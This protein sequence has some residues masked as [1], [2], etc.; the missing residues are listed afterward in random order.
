MLSLFCKLTAKCIGL[1]GKK[2]KKNRDKCPWHHC[3]A[4]ERLVEDGR[5]VGTKHASFK[6]IT[7]GVPDSWE[8]FQSSQMTL[9]QTVIWFIRSA[10]CCR[11]TH[12]LTAGQGTRAVLRANACD[13]LNGIDVGRE[14]G[15]DQSCHHHGACEGGRRRATWYF[16]KPLCSATLKTLSGKALRD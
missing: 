15:R 4:H 7:S 5:R 6:L 1:L 2:G 14:A 12:C 3:Q 13:T 9:F 16:K 11:Q 10:P 8:A